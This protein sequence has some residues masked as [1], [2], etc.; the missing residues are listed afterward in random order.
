MKDKDC[1]PLLWLRLVTHTFKP[2]NNMEVRD[3]FKLRK[4]G[5][6]EEAYAAIRP[7]YATHKGHYTTICM[8]WVGADMM[9]L[10]YKQRRLEEA[11][12]IFLALMRLYPTMDDKELRGQSAMMRAALHVFDHNPKFSML[13]FITK[14]DIHRLTNA[15][16]TMG[17]T[18]G[19]PVPSVGM[20]IVGKVFKEVAGNPTVDMAL[21]AAPI[22]AEA[23]RHSPYN[24]NNQRY[25]A[26]IYK[27]MG[28]TDKAVNIYRHLIAHHHQSHLYSEFA[29]LV[30]DAATRK[31][32]LCRTI[33]TQRE[34]RFTQKA[35]WQL[36]NLLYN[37]DNRR[38]R[39]ELDQCIAIRRNA[40]YNITWQMQ[41][42][43]ANLNGVEPVSEH[44]EREFYRQ[45]GEIV[46]KLRI[47]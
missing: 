29:E 13:D 32:L 20:R 47:Y 38:A 1:K 6:I 30:G 39:Y 27:I 36:A 33:A 37:V 28:K 18:G 23:L 4:E 41:N 16:W 8:F 17:N 12:K 43:N 31:A 2:T 5:K 19:H 46:D 22:L 42:L 26:L 35:R 7:M 10:R 34:Q 25:K 21:K 24:T 9:E 45:Q 15:D 3:V 14:W 44:D 11:Y 40:G